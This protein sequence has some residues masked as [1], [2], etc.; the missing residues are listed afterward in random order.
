M[1]RNLVVADENVHL[2][3]VVKVENENTKP[4]AVRLK[5][6]FLAFFIHAAV[7]AN[8]GKRAVA[9]ILEQDALVAVEFLRAARNSHAT[10]HVLLEAIGIMLEIH[11]D[12]A[13]DEDVEKTGSVDIAKGATGA[14]A[15][16]LD[17]GLPGHLAKATAALAVGLVVIEVAVSVARDEQVGI[18][19]VIVIPNSDPL[20]KAP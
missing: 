1:V 9:V 10:Y 6:R 7:L 15:I 12:I 13:A 2:A 18:T 4:L 14:P 11:D 20:A 5:T 8:I 3:V 17:A 16:R 19:V